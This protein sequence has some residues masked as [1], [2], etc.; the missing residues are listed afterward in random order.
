MKRV[1]GL[2]MILVA[3]VAACGSEA[4][5]ATATNGD[6]FCKLAEK[7]DADSKVLRSLGTDPKTAESAFAAAVTSSK[8]ALAKAPKDIVEPLKVVVKAQ[9]DVVA[10]LKKNDFDLTKAAG[11]K[12]LTTLLADKSVSAANDELDKY[13]G[14]KCSIAPSATTP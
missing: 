8:A 12:N 1:L 14:L 10:I 2:A 7:A 6:A 3:G 4:R 5:L 13:L 11:D 9:S